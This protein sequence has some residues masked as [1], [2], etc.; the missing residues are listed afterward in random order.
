MKEINL[1]NSVIPITKF[2][3]KTQECLDQL[4][5]NDSPIL[6]THN[7]ESAAVLITVED[8]QELKK[9]SAPSKSTNHNQKPREAEP[10]LK[11]E[12]NTV[13]TSKPKKSQRK[14]RGKK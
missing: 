13:N 4:R 10:E 5:V 8:Y 1:V 9:A 11:N 6:L 3:K 12:Q 7:G 2:K 14:K